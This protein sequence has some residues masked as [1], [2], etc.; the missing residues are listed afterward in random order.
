MTADPQPA[1]RWV[2][3][4]NDTFDRETPTSVEAEGVGLVPALVELWKRFL[5]ETVQSASSNREGSLESIPSRGFSEFTLIATAGGLHLQLAGSLVG[6][7]RLKTWMF[8]QQGSVGTADV[9]LLRDLAETHAS[10]G[11]I[12]DA[13]LAVLDAAEAAANRADF[14]GRLAQLRA[15]W[16]C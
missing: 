4:Y 7:H 15:R 3:V 10:S 11:S 8:A 1:L 13:A 5:F 14:E 16:D 2:V 9:V 6:A 12:E